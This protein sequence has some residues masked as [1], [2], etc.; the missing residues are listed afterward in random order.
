MNRDMV[1]LVRD[2]LYTHDG[3]MMIQQ[4]KHYAVIGHL[5]LYI[6]WINNIF[7]D[8]DLYANKLKREMPIM[9]INL[10]HKSILPGVLNE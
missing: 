8:R 9:F 2:F 7:P 1:E 5:K 4:L 6:Y 10:F 3:T